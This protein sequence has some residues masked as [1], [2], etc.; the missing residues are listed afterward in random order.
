MR[1]SPTRQVIT[2]SR[3]KDS[4][5]SFFFF[6]PAWD[7]ALLAMQT[8]F[9]VNP[10]KELSA[11]EV[12]QLYKLRVDV[13]VN[14][15]NCPYAEIDDTDAE[16]TTLHVT[17]WER[18]SYGRRN[19]V[20]TARLFPDEVDGEKVSHLGRFVV[21]PRHR[22]KGVASSLMLQTLK[23]S[24]EQSP[25]LPVYLTAQAPL[26]DYYAAF[27][28]TACGEEF[29]DEGIPHIPMCMSAAQLKKVIETTS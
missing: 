6:H 2:R 4:T 28:F 20:G 21:T 8:I 7:Y 27:G 15:Q 18:D 17:A 14:E 22:G 29:D 23:L 1:W 24:Y 25:D 11:L 13:F 3:I 19:I 26:Q 10:L 12:H 9:A 16:P 5:E